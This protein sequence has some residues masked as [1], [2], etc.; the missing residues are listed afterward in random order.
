[1]LR[2]GAARVIFA[3]KGMT[4]D[5]KREEVHLV[6]ILKSLG[7]CDIVMVEGFGREDIPCVEVAG[8]DWDSIPRGSKVIAI[9]GDVGEDADV[10]V[11]SHSDIEDIANFILDL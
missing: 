9:V 1:M 2:A 10:P 8:E 5:I 3:G 4:V 11:F 6:E 7:G